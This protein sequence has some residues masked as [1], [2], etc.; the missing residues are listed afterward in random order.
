MSFIYVLDSYDFERR[1]PAFECALDCIN[2]SIE[3][4]KAYCKMIGKKNNDTLYTRNDFGALIMDMFSRIITVHDEETHYGALH[5]SKRMEG[6]VRTCV[7]HHIGVLPEYRRKGYAK[8]LF[9]YLFSVTDC[10]EFQLGLMVDNIPALKLY[11]S[12]GFRMHSAFM[13]KSNS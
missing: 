5:Y 12:L 7:I 13:F 3:E 2:L 8:E 4:S 10:E 11:E 1:T 9:R 6:G